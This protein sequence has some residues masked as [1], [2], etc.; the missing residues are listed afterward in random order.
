MICFIEETGLV[1][2]LR[3]A[4]WEPALSAIQCGRWLGLQVGL[5]KFFVTIPG[6][7][8]SPVYEETKFLRVTW[9]H[10]QKY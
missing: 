1:D 10:H 9:A 6:Y 5:T 8:W 7:Y 4:H 2:L 3:M